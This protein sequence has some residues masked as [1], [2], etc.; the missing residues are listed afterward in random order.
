[1]TRGPRASRPTSDIRKPIGTLMPPKDTDVSVATVSLS[2]WPTSSAL[3]ERNSPGCLPGPAPPR[4][5]TP[6]D[7]GVEISSL[8]RP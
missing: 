1:M 6:T 5:A 2:V 3:T 4:P 7:I 8:T